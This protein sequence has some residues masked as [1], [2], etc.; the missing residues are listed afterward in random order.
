MCGI[1]GVLG[2]YSYTHKELT[3][4]SNKAS[5]RGPE[6]SVL[7]HITDGVTLGFHRLAIN[8]LDALSNQP[9]EH[10]GCYIVCNGE[11][12]NYKELYVENNITQP[13][14]RIV[15]LFCISIENMVWNTHSV[16]LMVYLPLFLLI[17]KPIR[18]LLLAIL[19]ESALCLFLNILQKTTTV[20][21]QK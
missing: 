8:G 15:K 11:I 12:Y 17:Q 4:A 7:Q 21:P 20:L 16:L 14:S 1:F 2:R 19:T 18:S 6:Y 5:Q 13:Q 3:D 9:I 10:D